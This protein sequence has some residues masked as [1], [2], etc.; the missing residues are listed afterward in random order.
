MPPRNVPG[1]EEGGQSGG[2]GLGLLHGGWSLPF[3]CQHLSALAAT[4]GGDPDLGLYNLRPAHVR[5]RARAQADQTPPLPSLL[6]VTSE[7]S[8]AL[9]QLPEF[10]GHLSQ[11]SGSPPWLQCR[12]NRMLFKNHLN[13]GCSGPSP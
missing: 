1:G 6:V 8:I 10:R 13:T 3:Q 7:H 4:P 9:S 5:M 2:S 11:F 12:K